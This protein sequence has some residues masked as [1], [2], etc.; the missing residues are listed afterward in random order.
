MSHESLVSLD[1]THSSRDGSAQRPR[2]YHGS[3]SFSRLPNSSSSSLAQ[4]SS[5]TLGEDVIPEIDNGNYPI[6]SRG[7]NIAPGHDDVFDNKESDGTE[8]LQ[9]GL[10]GEVVTSPIL[11]EDFHDLPVELMSMVNRFIDSLSAKVHAAPPSVDTLAQLFQ[12]FYL[13]AASN[14]ATHIS[15]LS[16]RLNRDTSPATPNSRGSGP[17]KS[18]ARTGSTGSRERM[19]SPTFRRAREQQ[20]LTAAEI[21]DRRRARR[22]LEKKEVA[23]QEAVERRV[24]EMVYDKIWRH[25]STDDEER[26]E[27]LRSRTA[28]LSV[29][30]IGLEELGIESD[31][32]NGEER[33]AEDQIRS[34]LSGARENLVKMNDEKYPLGKLAH[35]KMA[36]KSIVDTLSHFHPSSSSADEILPTLI[37]TLIT[38]PPEGINVISNLAFI[39]RFRAASKIDGEAAYCLTNLEAAITFLETVD[40]A[41]L[42]ADEALSG[43]PKSGSGTPT[44]SSE[45]GDPLD[46][47]PPI[48]FAPA[49]GTTTGITDKET[50]TPHPRS[51]TQPPSTQRL[52]GL[53]QRRISQLLQ[54]PTQAIGA[55]S[56]AVINRA[57]Q[58]F[59]TIGNTLENSYKLLFG[60]LKEH[61][62]SGVGLDGEG[63]STAIPKTLD[64]ARKLVANTSPN[65]ESVDLVD[66]QQDGAASSSSTTT[67]P[68]KLLGLFGGSSMLRER[69]NDSDKSAPGTVRIHQLAETEP[70]PPPSRSRAASGV[71]AVRP[72][73]PTSASFN[74]AAEL[75]NLGNQLNPLNRLA[76]INVMR[77]GRS[78]TAGASVTAPTSA[79]LTSAARPRSRDSTASPSRTAD[80]SGEPG[81]VA[82]LTSTF[83]DL[84]AAL[85]PRESRKQ[86]PI[87]PPIRKFMELENPADLKIS[88]VMEL[89]RD[90]R[91]L[92]TA[93]KETGAV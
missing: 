91:R 44:P 62:L 17:S 38:T 72:P 87:A 80:V 31:S 53:H 29:V 41:S 27:K 60:R 36:H 16:S 6:T 65:D 13:Q 75:R 37:Y 70:P 2:N 4:L 61:E 9:S 43:P 77:F 52:T 76:G 73:T 85:T 67:K 71:K 3:R 92:A 40:L 46:V 34:W 19:D 14:I 47:V 49:E 57:D 42:R 22:L 35:L 55:A 93:L 90:Y 39:Q 82:D 64:D 78:S 68:D 10:F 59:K 24:C 54:P 66:A 32:G 1:S 20:M 83:P 30:G 74:P 58:G 81:P 12:D 69:S 23:F 7:S 26:D 25:R 84:V 33:I 63:K 11:S 21:E 88:E 28:A 45:T 18:S 51:L 15:I 56:D 50:H 89:L 8:S 48:P 86:T 5:S 79:P